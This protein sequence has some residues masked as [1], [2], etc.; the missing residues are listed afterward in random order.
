MPVDTFWTTYGPGGS[1]L[2]QPTPGDAFTQPYHILPGS[3]GVDYTNP[4]VWI[5][6]GLVFPHPSPFPDRPD[7]ASA[8]VAQFMS[9]H[10]R[11]QVDYILERGST[12]YSPDPGVPVP[13]P[14]PEGTT[15]VRYVSF[16]NGPTFLLGQDGRTIYNIQ[17]LRP[18]DIVTMPLA[19]QQVLAV[20]LRNPD[21]PA[22][23]NPVDLFAAQK[24]LLMLR[25]R[26][27]ETVEAVR[28]EY[29]AQ[30][31][32]VIDRITAATD[33]DPAGRDTFLEKFLFDPAVRIANYPHLF[34]EQLNLYKLRLEGMA[35]FHDNRISDFLRDLNQRFDRIRQYFAVS[36]E[37]PAGSGLI[38][39]VNAVDGNQALPTMAR[40]LNIFVE[41]ESQLFQIA[42]S[43]AYVTM[44]GTVF[45][46]ITGRLMTTQQLLDAARLADSS[47]S[48]LGSFLRA[49][50]TD[51]Y[52]RTL[53]GT[54]R[55]RFLDGPNLIFVLQTF[56]NYEAEAEAQ[57]KSEDI[58]QQTKLLEDYSKMQE[59]LNQTLNK[60]SPQPAASGT[61]TPPPEKLAL[62]KL[63][64]VSQLEPEQLRIV[65]MFDRIAAA[66]GNTSYHPIEAQ[67]TD[68]AN[69]GGFRPT[70]DIAAGGVLIAHPKSVWDALA[71]NLGEA[72]K[73]IGQDS[74]LRMDEINRLSQQK[75]RNYELGSNVLN[76]LTELLREITS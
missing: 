38:G 8:T 74:Q 29:L 70:M 19:D 34:V 71:I 73:I 47:Y 13:S 61:E 62:L 46:P 40:G 43:R 24:D 45:E 9:W 3:A 63:N 60:F 76:K 39:G 57:I 11:H 53:D 2:I 65:S 10:S 5:D 59:L 15:T 67:K 48:D 50:T 23:D 20:P 16:A 26:A 72:T 28:A 54:S 75:N 27:G 6:A 37:T 56:D 33:Y 44:T 21:L 41:M 35:L 32:A 30:V 69:P 64:L 31:Q 14:L 22:V 1:N 18:T 12:G 52:G 68:A 66:V 51:I 58:Q 49:Q 55:Q 25:P 17:A 4:Q 42:L 7:F 36:P